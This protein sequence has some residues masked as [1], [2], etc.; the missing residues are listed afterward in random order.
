MRWAVD[1]NVLRERLLELN[2]A[3][4][5]S[6]LDTLVFTADAMKSGVAAFLASNNYTRHVGKLPPRRR[7]GTGL[8]TRV[9]DLVKYPMRRLGRLNDE[10]DRLVRDFE[11]GVD[12]DC[13]GEPYEW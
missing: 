5:K 8:R 13:S 1:V 4:W 11:P 9:L 6:L 7:I 3:K 2:M 12:C 10:I